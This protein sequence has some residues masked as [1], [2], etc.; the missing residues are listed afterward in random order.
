MADD[1]VRDTEENIW[2][3]RDDLRDGDTPGKRTSNALSVSTSPF[4]YLLKIHISLLEDPLF[5]EPS[6][7][8][9]NW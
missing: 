1:R 4:I 6:A 9:K 7:L 8:N 2:K 5:K 3:E